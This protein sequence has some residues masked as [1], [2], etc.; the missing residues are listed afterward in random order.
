M[1][2]RWGVSGE[3]T[4]GSYNGNNANRLEIIAQRGDSNGKDTDTLFF[5]KERI[6]SPE[7]AVARHGSSTNIY[8]VYFD[9]L[10]EEIRFKY[11]NLLDTSSS[12]CNFGNFSDSYRH[13]TVN[14]GEN[15]NSGKYSTEHVNVIAGS[16]TGRNAGEYVSLGVISKEE[17]AVDEE[18]AAVD[19]VVVLVWWD[20]YNNKLMY[21]YNIKPTSGTTGASVDNWSTPYEIFAE[22]GNTVLL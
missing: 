21:T 9:N 7:Y 6:K 12:K 4:T 20:S 18:E 13:G 5:D 1:T 14:N 10:N 22:G 17:A 2:D 19:D 11:G 16:T 3:A 8:L 15:L